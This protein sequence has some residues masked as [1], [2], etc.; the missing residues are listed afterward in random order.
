MTDKP[1]TIDEYLAAVEPAFRTEL[2]RI[3]ELVTASSQ[4]SRR[5]SATACPL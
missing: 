3:R 1:T 4:R 5:R 2:Q